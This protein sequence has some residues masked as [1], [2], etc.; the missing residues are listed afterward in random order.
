LKKDSPK[1]ERKKKKYPIANRKK[2]EGFSTRT[3][4]LKGPVSLFNKKKGKRTG[5]GKT[6]FLLEKEKK[7][8][9]IQMRYAVK[10]G[11]K[12]IANLATAWGK[13]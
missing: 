11:K 7:K 1:K 5:R 12:G 10:G 2:K 3:A 6:H 8:N 13:I 4:D 9:A